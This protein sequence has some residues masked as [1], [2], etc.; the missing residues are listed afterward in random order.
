[1]H[2]LKDQKEGLQLI[3]NLQVVRRGLLV[4]F[5]ILLFV[6]KDITGMKFFFSNLFIPFLET[7]LQKFWLVAY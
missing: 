3:Y 5:F 1:M 7:I 4:L 6:I 2:H